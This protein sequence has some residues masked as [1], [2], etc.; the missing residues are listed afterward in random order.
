MG[1]S[2]ARLDKQEGIPVAGKG[3]VLPFRA[4]RE[5]VSRCGA[6]W[7]S[8]LAGAFLSLK[9]F[10]LWNKFLREN[11]RAGFWGKRELA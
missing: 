9:F 3:T 6:N 4:S 5:T 10:F 8:H 11:H 7:R 2:R 1:K